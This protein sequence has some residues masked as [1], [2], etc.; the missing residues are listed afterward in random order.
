MYSTG[1]MCE[2]ASALTE[3]HVLDFTACVSESQCPYSSG[4]RSAC[5]GKDPR[6]RISAPHQRRGSGLF[7]VV[8]IFPN[9]PI[10]KY[11]HP[12]I[13]PTQSK[14]K[15]HSSITL[16]SQSLR[17]RTRLFS[18]HGCCEFGV[19]FAGT[20]GHNQC[21]SSIRVMS[22]TMGPGFSPPKVR[23][24][25]KHP[26]RVGGWENFDLRLSA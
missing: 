15:F 16:R 7:F 18:D 13:F 1:N 26:P 17:Q 5:N 3:E 20:T 6:D 2:L 4:M 22:S 12:Q 25:P 9:C 14:H 24:I 21:K 10:N 19:S 8:M 11:I 23:L